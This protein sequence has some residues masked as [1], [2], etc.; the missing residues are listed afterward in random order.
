MEESKVKALDTII[1]LFLMSDVRLV[2][3]TF[4]LTGIVVY[5]VEYR[6][7]RS[8]TANQREARFTKLVSHTYIWGSV[9]VIIGVQV[10]GW[11]V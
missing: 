7:F 4:L 6:E 8:K 3:A 1:S 10:L 11:F 5:L 2:T 9:G